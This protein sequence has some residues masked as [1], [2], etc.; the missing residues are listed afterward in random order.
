ME[1]NT[2]KQTQ[3]R[4]AID[5]D[6]KMMPTALEATKPPLTVDMLCRLAH[7]PDGGEVLTEI[8][9]TIDMDTLIAALPTL[10]D[11]PSYERIFTQL[12]DLVGWGIKRHFQPQMIWGE[13]WFWGSVGEHTYGQPRIG[14]YP[15]ACLTIGRY[16]SLAENVTFILG[17]HRLDCVSTY[18]FQSGAGWPSQRTDNGHNEVV[19]ANIDVGNDVWIGYGVTVLAGTRIGNGAVIAANAVARGNIPPYS[20]Y[21]GNPIRHIRNRFD[22]ATITRLETI[23]WWNWP[24]W[25]VDRISHLL[26]SPD[27]NVF[28]DAAEAASR[29][30]PGG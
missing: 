3:N 25:K 8:L 10:A 28:L 6:P 11:S 19:A 22:D 27:I 16:C 17:N 15:G 4:I 23:A 9:P 2:V 20:I 13:G 1:D 30:D 14:P 29:V 24:D 7:Q 12:R 26:L 18:P 21:G 5:D